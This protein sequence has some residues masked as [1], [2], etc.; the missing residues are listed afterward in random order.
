MTYFH[1]LSRQ[2]QRECL[3]YWRSP[4]TIL[5]AFLFFVM[6]L[7][8]FPLT[9]PPEQHIVST[10]LPGLLWIALLLAFLF[11]AERL[12]ME[13]YQDGVIEQWLVS[14]QPLSIYVFAKIAVHWLLCIVPLFISLPII[15]AL[16]HMSWNQCW[17][18]AASILTGTPALWFLCALA[19][20][21][22]SHAQQKGVLVA[23]ILLPLALPIMIFGAGAMT[24]WNE[25]SQVQGA[26]ALLAACSLMAV[27]FLPTAI[28]AVLR[29]SH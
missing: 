3:M 6:V 21:L 24:A 18:T 26:L 1:A 2:C 5:Y 12:F 27:T 22:S 17:V 15:A 19:S 23:L 9:I 25:L 28:C 4:R 20:A 7:V 14:G 10:L 16:Y 8:F 29:Q 11:A 13:D